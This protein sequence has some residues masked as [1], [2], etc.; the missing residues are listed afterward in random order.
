[1]V[2]YSGLSFFTYLVQL[3]LLTMIMTDDGD[4][5]VLWTLRW[6]KS[7]SDVYDGVHSD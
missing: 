3:K 6:V 7:N 2:D 1:V 5:V 4:G